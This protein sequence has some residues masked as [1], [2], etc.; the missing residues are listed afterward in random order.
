MQEETGYWTGKKGVWTG[1][2]LCLHAPNG[3]G[4]VNTVQGSAN[5][6]GLVN[7]VQ[8]LCVAAATCSSMYRVTVLV[9]GLGRVYQKGWLPRTLR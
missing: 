1:Q 8:G 4:L 7:T 6:V 5:G 9:E 2:P 3:V